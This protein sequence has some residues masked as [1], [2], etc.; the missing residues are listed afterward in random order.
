MDKN[1][2]ELI[3]RQ[4]KRVAKLKECLGKEV[5]VLY[6]GFGGFNNPDTDR[7]KLSQATDDGISF[8]GQRCPLIGCGCGVLKVSCE[9]ETAYDITSLVESFPSGSPQSQQYEL[10]RRVLGSAAMFK[11]KIADETVAL[12]DRKKNIK[13]NTT[14]LDNRETVLKSG[15]PYI[16]DDLQNKW[17]EYIF[18]QINDTNLDA[19]C[20]AAYVEIMFIGAVDIMKVLSENIPFEKVESSLP[21]RGHSGN[22]FGNAVRIA[23]MF[24]DKGKLY[25]EY[26]KSLRTK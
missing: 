17:R 21:D 20:A 25:F 16:N 1:Q 15:A 22:T 8:G 26:R 14:S 12:E 10:I 3:K 24:T 19:H 13:T 9:G 6:A 18:K 4:A 5:V 7:G 11:K 2:V 23:A